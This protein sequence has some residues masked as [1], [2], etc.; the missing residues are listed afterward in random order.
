MSSRGSITIGELQGK[1]TMLEVACHRCERR[2][3]VSL[4]RLIEE[5][6]ADMGLPDLWRASRAIART[7]TQRRC[8]V[9][10]P[11]TIR[12]CRRCFCRA[13]KPNAGL[14]AAVAL[15]KVPAIMRAAPSRSGAALSP[16]RCLAQR[17]YRLRAPPQGA[18]A[19]YRWRTRPL[20]DAWPGSSERQAN[21]THFRGS[22]LS[23]ADEF[24]QPA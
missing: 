12:N 8:I 10:V 22:E 20:P 16:L 13:R 17:V 6:G 4:A 24:S 5:H 14:G 21:R 2:G 23:A 11:S 3:R 9:A 7:R 15:V 19:L 1:L 18:F